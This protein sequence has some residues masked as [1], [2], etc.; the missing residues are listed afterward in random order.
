MHVLKFVRKKLRLNSVA[1]F[2]GLNS[3]PWVQ[4]VGN[5][6]GVGNGCKY[7]ITRKLCVALFLVDRG[8]RMLQ[9][10]SWV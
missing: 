6:K 1:T 2:A 9:A 10:Y 4:L 7:L 8:I 5:N 3:M